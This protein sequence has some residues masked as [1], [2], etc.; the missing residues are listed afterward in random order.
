MLKV[1]IIGVGGIAGLHVPGWNT[2]N[3]AEI[4]AGCD[5]NEE[6][7]Q[8]WGREHS[9]KRLYADA[10]DMFQN[11]DIDIVDICAP[12]TLH[13]PLAIAALEAGKHVLCEKPLAPTP[14]EI[15]QMMAARDRAGTLLMT[16]QSMRF[17]GRAKAFKTEVDTGVLGQVYHARS[18]YLRRG[19]VPIGPGF[20]LRDDRGGGTCVD[21]G[22]HVLDF[23]LW[24]M[25]NPHPVAVSG[26][27]CAGLE[28]QEGPFSGG[29]QAAIPG[30]REVED[31]VSGFVRFD[32]GA[33]LI[34]EV[35]WLLHGTDENQTWLYGSEGG[36]HWPSC[37]FYETSYATRQQFDR[38][39][40]LLDEGPP[41]HAQECVEFARAVAGGGPSPVPAEESLQVMTILD[42]IY[43]SQQ[44]G[45]E[46]LLD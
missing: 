19:G 22:V 16:A 5:L 8:N 6:A 29:G 13:A 2:S 34:L 31:F 11:P 41:S 23:A 4:V 17:G 37:T 39:L 21:I 42:G 7:L 35:S 36:C 38:T 24:L 28:N 25:C 10:G 3:E 33:S 40:Q 46:V 18:W 12:D 30:E 45:R 1:G 9:V 43:R 26:V 44:S 20:I 15:R 32:S 14:D 27:A